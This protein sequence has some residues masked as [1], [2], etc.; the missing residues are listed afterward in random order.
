MKMCQAF[1]KQGHDVTLI[2]QEKSSLLESGV[3]D[4][5]SFYGVEKCFQIIK[6]AKFPIKKAR[7]LAYAWT[8]AQRAKNITPDIVYSRNDRSVCFS[9]LLKIPTIFESHEPLRGNDWLS[10]WMF[11]KFCRS[12]WLVKIVVITHALREHFYKNYP[13]FREEIQVAPDGADPMPEH[14]QPVKLAETGKS[15]QVGYVGH[16]YK[17]KGIEIIAKLA[18][19]CPWACFHVVGGTENDLAC[20]KNKLAYMASP[21]I[22]ISPNIIFHGHVP[23][24][25]TMAYIKAFDVVL[26]PNQHF[27]MG[28]DKN[29]E[30][31]ADKNIAPWTSPLKL[32][33]YMAAGKP[34]I[35]SDLPVLREV[36]RPEDNAL[37][38]QSDNVEAWAQAL[39]RL[40]DD[41]GLRQRIG[42]AALK[43]FE[44]NYTWLARADKVLE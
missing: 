25:K 42:N 17:G 34:I 30:V 9:T 40:R 27:V 1:A 2:T 7:K 24:N 20:W 6:L 26:L 44:K 11:K 18:D 19:K 32:F 21:T 8:A 22:D 23:P 29:K 43:D 28:Y 4:V 37:L 14:M 38:C 13:G 31:S 12:R 33:E 15:L 36:L 3:S 41:H 16:L 10:K 39:A 35:A 5:F